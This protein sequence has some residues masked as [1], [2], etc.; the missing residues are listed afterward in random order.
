[1]SPG[2][3]LVV[4][5]GLAGLAAAHRLQSLGWSVAVFE[6]RGRAGGK[7]A[8]ESLGGHE[9]E[10]WPGVVPRSAPALCELSH[11]LGAGD[12][13][14][15]APLCLPVTLPAL[16][17]R[18][19]F[20][21]WRRR[22]LALIASWLG[23]A[24][25]PDLPW[26][27]TRLDDRSVADFSQVYLGRRAHEAALEPLFAR[28]FGI[29]TRET[30]RELLFALCDA[31]GA[32]ALDS[33]EG[34]GRLA[35]AL[36]AGL[37]LRLE[38]RAES[39]EPD[40][41]A[42]RLAS[43][44]RET[45]DAV[46]VATGLRE[47]ERLLGKLAPAADAAFGALRTQSALALAVATRGEV[48][49]EELWIPRRDGGELAAI[50]A[51]G[52]RLLSLVARP[53]LAARHGHRPDPELTHFLVEAAARALPGLATEI[54]TTRLHRF[55][56]L[57]AFAVGHYRALAHAAPGCAGD[58][59]AAPHVEGELTSGLRAARELAASVC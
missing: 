13:L 37:D 28:A 48:T 25:D 16:L 15:R 51:R 58:W 1:M 45:A 29:D 31:S 5:A 17:R 24:L 42:L 7:H 47:A 49:R 11:E 20:G 14:Q 46:I 38:T 4:G 55:P 23:G 8:C 9:Y 39:V 50:C 12:L 40:R 56:A 2:R 59:C 21:P 33:L 22:R 26:R 30:S 52:P 41:R 3:A 34:A 18:S 10:P 35:Q 32:P 36:A 6:A 43:G 27:E 54:E 53:E 19:P 44:G 57:P